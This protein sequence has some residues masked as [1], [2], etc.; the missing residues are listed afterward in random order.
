M[1]VTRTSDKFYMQFPPK[2]K[3][4]PTNVCAYTY[5]YTYHTHTLHTHNTRC[6]H[7]AL[8]IMLANSFHPPCSPLV[9]IYFSWINCYPATIQGRNVLCGYQNAQGACLFVYFSLTLGEAPESKGAAAP[10][11][12]LLAPP[13]AS[14]S[15]TT[16]APFQALLP[17][18]REA[19]ASTGQCE[20]G[21]T[22]SYS[23]THTDNKITLQHKGIV[24]V[25]R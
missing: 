9:K 21:N 20:E 15:L 2:L 1:K 23:P 3:K 8:T 14:C 17:W 13:Q 4:I 12:S 11:T 16:H 25:T 18:G 6:Q 7:C 24:S 22:H 5:T 10:G 19:A